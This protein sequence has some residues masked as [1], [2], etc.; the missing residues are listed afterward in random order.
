MPWALLT[1]LFDASCPADTRGTEV[2]NAQFKAQKLAS[3]SSEQDSPMHAAPFLELEL[4]LLDLRLG[5]LALKTHVFA[6]RQPNNENFKLQL[7][8]C[9]GQASALVGDTGTAINVLKTAVRGT[10]VSHSCLVCSVL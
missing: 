1:M 9:K 8:L 6:Q 2:R 4:L 3:E 5:S 10:G 7:I